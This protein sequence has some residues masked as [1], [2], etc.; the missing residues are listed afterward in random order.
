M[1]T[2]Q[3]SVALDGLTAT[4]TNLMPAP[5]N[6]WDFGDGQHLVSTHAVHEYD[7]SGSY[8]VSL[9]VIDD[10]GADTEERTIQVLEQAD[11]LLAF[12]FSLSFPASF[13]RT[14]NPLRTERLNYAGSWLERP[15]IKVIGPYSGAVV[16]NTGT[17]VS[18]AFVVGIGEDDYRQVDW[19][20][21]DQ[22]WFVIDREGNYVWHELS[23]DSN[24]LDFGILPEHLIDGPQRIEGQISGGNERSGIR[25]EYHERFI[26]I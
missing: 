12:D 5:Q 25:V 8:R 13:G 15:T 19:N 4:F 11:E 3:F 6:I 16:R 17:G 9:T 22:A 21:N 18:F 20:A 7:R 26:G 24:L 1:P 10:I 14:G 2:A 23:P